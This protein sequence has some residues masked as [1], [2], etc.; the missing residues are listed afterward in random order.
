MNAARLTQHHTT[1]T[2]AR[3][4][5]VWRVLFH[6]SE[7]VALADAGDEIDPSTCFIGPG[8][9]LHP[10]E[11]PSREIAEEKAQDLLREAAG[12]SGFAALTYRGVVRVHGAGD[13]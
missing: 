4:P 11:W 12:C 3:Q 2:D 13:A 6:L 1:Q 10:D 7:R 8:D 5:Q 9:W